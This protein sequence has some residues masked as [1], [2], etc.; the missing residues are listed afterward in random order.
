MIESKETVIN[1]KKFL[2]TQFMARDGLK[3]Q[4]RLIK[5]VG[6]VVASMASFSSSDE[7]DA[8]IDVSAIAKALS[9]TIDEDSCFNL[10][11]DLLKNVKYKNQDLR[12]IDFDIAFA[13]D[14]KALFELIYFIIDFNYGNFFGVGGI[15]SLFKSNP[16]TMVHESFTKNV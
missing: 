14:Y 4:F 1:N 13:G 6:P 11:M 3:L 8:Q 2:V 5:Q 9:Q 10:V 15:G 12:E 7:D 16:S